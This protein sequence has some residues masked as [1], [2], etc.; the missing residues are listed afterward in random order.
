MPTPVLEPE[1]QEVEDRLLE[2]Y[3]SL[4]PTSY[5][6]WGPWRSGSSEDLSDAGLARWEK[7]LHDI[8]IA[9][10]AAHSACHSRVDEVALGELRRFLDQQILIH[11]KQRP[12]TSRASAYTQ[13]CCLA[14]LPLFVGPSVEKHRRIDSGILDQRIEGCVDWLKIGEQR[15]KA[16]TL[17]FT[18]RDRSVVS[19]LRLQLVQSDYA[20]NKTCQRILELL[21]RWQGSAFQTSSNPVRLDPVSFMHSILGVSLSLTALGRVISKRLL[22]EISHLEHALKE[23]SDSDLSSDTLEGRASQPAE[24]LDR[25]DDFIRAYARGRFLKS[26]GPKPS[27][28]GRPSFLEAVVSESLYL[29]P[30]AL[31]NSPNGSGTLLINP[32]NLQDASSPL[33]RANLA[34]TLA[35][36]L[37]PGHDEHYRRGHSSPL[38][39]LYEITRSMVGLE[40][41]AFF[42]ES[43][44]L[45]IKDTF[46][47][48]EVAV[49]FQRARRF[50][51]V[52]E[53]LRQ[54]THSK[55]NARGYLIE[56]F[57]PLPSSEKAKLL[58]YI[59]AD[60]PHWLR[61]LAYC[62][63]L[64]ETENA[65]ST[66]AR[67]QSTDIDASVVE[68]YLEWGPL[69]PSQVAKLALEYG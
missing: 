47:L 15:L 11:V 33:L 5:S 42:A 48:A 34:L 51:T 29:P 27:L 22:R 38:S 53:Q 54:I 10:S 41:W 57:S 50:G 46:P 1:V 4:Q 36:E 21:E 20:S 17:T 26:V 67:N 25:M 61:L 44:I 6:I 45:G 28:V 43:S 18:E 8:S 49:Y 12:Y 40:G 3:S 63:G 65:L 64:I 68:A 52:L 32:L 66:I 19:K 60:G 58:H 2:S 56:M 55:E 35:H 13:L 69:N 62:V 31:G 24:W 37:C 7:T 9:V 23:S 30:T 59:E 14:L 16:G 39:R